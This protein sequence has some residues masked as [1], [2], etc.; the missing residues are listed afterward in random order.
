MMHFFSKGVT[1]TAVTFSEFEGQ[2][3]SHLM[4]GNSS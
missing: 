4:R 3:S 2:F 1:V